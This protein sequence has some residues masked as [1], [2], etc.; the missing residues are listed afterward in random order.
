MSRHVPLSDDTILGAIA[1]Q[2][3]TI[4]G[5][6]WG[7]ETRFAVLDVD[8][9]SQYHNELGLARL[10]HSLASIGLN[11]HQ[12][13]QS[14]D[15]AGWHLYISFSSWVNC[16]TV[17][18]TLKQWLMAEGYE[19]KPGQLEIFPSNNGLR[20]PL[21]R[22][23]AWL[24]D[25]GAV[26]VRRVEITAD[27]AISRLLDDL[28]ASAHNWGLVEEHITRRLQ[29]IQAATAAA[30]PAR[31]LRNENV[32]EDGF[33][34]FFT[35]AGMI[36]EVYDFGQAY[37]LNGLTA[38]S[39]RHHAVLCVG[40][41]LWYGD[42]SE[43]VRALPGVGR[44]D[45]RAAVIETWLKE[46]HN[47]FSESVLRGDWQE[48][49]TDIRRACNWQATEEVERPRTSYPLTD[50][51]I[52][53]LEGLTKQT[54][55]AW[56]PEDFEKGNIGREETA[57]E[58][59]RA[60][61]IK[62]VE[63]GR[64]VTLRG[65]MRLS[66]CRHETVRR[67]TDIWGVF[68]LQSVLGDLSGGGVRLLHAPSSPTVSDLVLT[69]EAPVDFLVVQQFCSVEPALPVLGQPVLLPGDVLANES[70][71]SRLSILGSFGS[72]PSCWYS[73][74]V[75]DVAGGVERS[76]NGPGRFKISTRQTRSVARVTCDYPV[77]LLA[78]SRQR[79]AAKDRR[80]AEPHRRNITSRAK[81]VDR[82]VRQDKGRTAASKLTKQHED[83][84]ALLKTWQ[85]GINR[86]RSGKHL[87]WLGLAMLP[88]QSRAP[89]LRRKCWL[90]VIGG[91]VWP[92]AGS[93]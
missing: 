91:F 92:T 71:V 53:R 26:K 81:S 58:K 13:Y 29:E 36:P 39:Q 72:H 79:N 61:L 22:G 47:G 60:A 37:W 64:R 65:L 21:Q 89:P 59:I 8:E 62:L 63:A 1:L 44:A 30:M 9:T 2:D 88:R 86:C 14:S 40:H 7:A 45:Q 52:D 24:D 70:S 69:Q 33:S 93:V 34:S 6:R 43:G 11:C 27:E 19:I 90:S 18:K 38:P 20:L 82:S 5:C 50:R 55:R 83:F 49:G 10:R 15:S 54:G 32:E 35:N 48:I 85:R 57:R 77:D 23:F 67:H 28:E 31:E 76:G 66:G 68:K 3:D 73:G 56:Y 75:P 4:W 51:A 46:K 25:R 78:W 87:L 74:S 41:Y 17:H 42:E 80:E 84:K 12:N 16:E